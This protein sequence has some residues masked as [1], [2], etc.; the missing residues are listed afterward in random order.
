M[1]EKFIEVYD[2]ILPK[3]LEDKIESLILDVNFLPLFPL[4]YQSNN[5]YTTDHPLYSFTP[6]LFH[7]FKNGDTYSKYED[8][9]SQ[10][11]YNFCSKRNI[12]VNHFFK[13]KV[14]VDL[15]SPNPGLDLPPHIDIPGR[16]HW[17]LL[18]YINDSDGDTVLFKDDQTTE[19]KRV[20]PKK[21]RMVFFDGSIPH[22][23]SRSA[24]NT[25]SAVNFNFIG[26]KL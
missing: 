6:G 18:Y 13:G 4:Y 23:G 20:T 11:L 8:F 16:N 25:R 19:I 26:E 1:M 14:F 17:V 21:G 9:L 2:N 5:T 15:P 3:K 7:T 10:V 22:C 12:I 24:T